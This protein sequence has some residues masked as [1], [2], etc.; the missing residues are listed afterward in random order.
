M[1]KNI[2][3]NKRQVIKEVEKVV[4]SVMK[5][6]GKFDEIDK[7]QFDEILGK[8]VEQV[9]LRRGLKLSQVASKTHDVMEA[10]P[11]EYGK[12]SED[13]R[14]WEALIAY[15]YLKYHALLEIF[16]NMYLDDLPFFLER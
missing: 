9:Q 1:K 16:P 7:E 12:L 8:V 3:R 5:I 11:E 15:L 13:M 2:P 10:M 14:S 6:V 4:D